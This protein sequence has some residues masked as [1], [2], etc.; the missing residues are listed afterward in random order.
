MN[1]EMPNP[2]AFTAVP[3]LLPGDRV[4]I[5]SPSFA[6]P[7]FAP[8]VHERAMLRLIAET[9]LIPV[10]YPTTRTLGARAEDR[11]ADINAAFADR[12]IRGI[13]TTVGGDDQITVVPH[14][15]AEVATA[16]PKPFFGYSDNTNILNWLW[17]LGIPEYY[18]G[19][20]QMHLARPPHR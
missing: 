19:S 17:S 16:D 9:G 6:A 11:A 3:K 18:G 10:E 20:T 7:G 8:V 1:K 4:A 5:L 2:V 15:N 14:L 13:I 12:T